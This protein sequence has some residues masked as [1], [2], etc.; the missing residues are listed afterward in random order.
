MLD[1][2]GIGDG[3]IHDVSHT[4]KRLFFVVHVVGKLEGVCYRVIGRKIGLM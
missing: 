1:E 2:S 4:T 3:N